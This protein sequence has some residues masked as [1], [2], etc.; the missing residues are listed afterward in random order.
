MDFC[1]D[2]RYSP[3]VLW[4][5]PT[6]P[7]SQAFSPAAERPLISVPYVYR[8]VSPL[9]LLAQ[10]LSSRHPQYLYKSM[11]LSVPL[12]TEYF[13]T[14]AIV[15]SVSCPFIP[16]H[17]FVKIILCIVAQP[18]GYGNREMFLSDASISQ[19]DCPPRKAHPTQ[20]ADSDTSEMPG[21]V[22]RP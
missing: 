14:A 1:A 22:L 11:T 18:A 17:L 4:T 19:A 7:L 3:D 20:P 8:K 5:M 9:Y 21:V 15:V 12:P 16:F 10:P 2:R 6:F 13:C